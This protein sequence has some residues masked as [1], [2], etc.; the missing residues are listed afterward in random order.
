MPPCVLAHEVLE[1]VIRLPVLAGLLL[2]GD[3]TLLLEPPR[4]PADEVNAR[5]DRIE[6]IAALVAAFLEIFEID[7]RRVARIGAVQ[8]NLARVI[9]RVRL[10]DRPGEIIV[11]FDDKA[12]I[13]GELTSEVRDQGHAEEIG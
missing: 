7:L 5:D 12:R 10:E 8:S 9:L 3:Q 1:F 2:F 13:A 4:Q 11:M 6:V